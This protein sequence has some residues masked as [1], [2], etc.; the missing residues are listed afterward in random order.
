MLRNGDAP[1]FFWGNPGSD[2]SGCLLGR[3]PRMSAVCG[4]A[5]GASGT[6]VVEAPLVL[7]LHAP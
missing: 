4:P 6:G 5:D 2:D 1:L 3:V 7:S